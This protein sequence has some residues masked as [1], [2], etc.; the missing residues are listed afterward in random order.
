MVDL[1][2]LTAPTTA[3][4][5]AAFRMA[6]KAYEKRKTRAAQVAATMEQAAADAEICA[7]QKNEKTSSALEGDGFEVPAALEA[8]TAAIRAM[9]KLSDEHSEQARAPHTNGPREVPR[10]GAPSYY[11][12]RFS[13]GGY[14]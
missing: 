4:K 12:S 13:T 11:K 10:C 6:R 7:P 14:I 2:S 1:Y 9:V 5:E 3:R 8:I